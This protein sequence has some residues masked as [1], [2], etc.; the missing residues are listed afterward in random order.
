MGLEKKMTKMQ[1]SELVLDS[2]G[3][4]MVPSLQS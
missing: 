3:Q 4:R 2:V 1:G